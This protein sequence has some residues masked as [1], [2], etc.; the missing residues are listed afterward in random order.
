MQFHHNPANINKKGQPP[1]DSA[2]SKLHSVTGWLLK[3]TQLHFCNTLEQTNFTSV[4][5]E[6]PSEHNCHECV[7]VVPRGLVYS[8]VVWDCAYYIDSDG[9]YSLGWGGL[10]RGHWPCR[11]NGDYQFMKNRAAKESLWFRMVWRV[12]VYT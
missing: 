7:Y 4:H 8:R 9:V 10:V 1:L 3:L 6:Q 12:C 5:I 2:S 11:Y